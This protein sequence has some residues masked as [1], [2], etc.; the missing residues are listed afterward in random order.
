MLRHGKRV[1]VVVSPAWH[2]GA[3]GMDVLAR[4]GMDRWIAMRQYL[5]ATARQAWFDA[6]SA[7]GGKAATLKSAAAACEAALSEM[8]RLEAAQ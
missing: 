8:D 1:A 4:T 5:E 6:G 3:A 7:D 2:E